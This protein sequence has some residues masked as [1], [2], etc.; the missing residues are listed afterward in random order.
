VQI[1]LSQR[2]GGWHYTGIRFERYAERMIIDASRV[3]IA[4]SILQKLDSR[5]TQ[6]VLSIHLTKTKIVCLTRKTTTHNTSTVHSFESDSYRMGGFL[7]TPK[8]VKE[9]G[10]PI[11]I[12][13]KMLIPPSPSHS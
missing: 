6:C 3:Q 13:S 12:G 9:V 8:W 10:D 1:K 7:V 2:R 4:Q 5:F 11:A